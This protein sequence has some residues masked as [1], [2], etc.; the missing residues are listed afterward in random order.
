[1]MNFHAYNFY[2]LQCKQ[3]GP[4]G[5]DIYWYFLNIYLR[6]FVFFYFLFF[7]TSRNTNLD[8][9]LYFILMMRAFRGISPMR[10]NPL[11]H[12]H[13][14]HIWAKLIKKVNQTQDLEPQTCADNSIRW[15]VLGHSIAQNKHILKMGYWGSGFSKLCIIFI[16]ILVKGGPRAMS[17]ITI[18]FFGA[19]H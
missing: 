7:T 14:P 17:L 10:M 1:M 18:L 13:D 6:V 16:F 9:F 5:E 19:K 12:T 2:A 3:R 4:N 11:R 15:W 8:F